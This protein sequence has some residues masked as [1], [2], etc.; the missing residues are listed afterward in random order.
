MSTYWPTEDG[1]PYAD[2]EREEA[3]LGAECD[4]DLLS[5]R[6]RSSHLFDDLDPLERQVIESRFGLGGAPIR[7]MKQLQHDT[8]V[9]RA[10][11]R[12]ALGSGLG[13]IRSHL[14]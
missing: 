11:L 2:V 12:E 13:K 6:A 4:D 3:D 8:G 9:P 5:L 14:I 7:S 10:D 1:W